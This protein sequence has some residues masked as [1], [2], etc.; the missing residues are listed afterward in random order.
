MGI[1]LSHFRTPEKQPENI[2]IATCIFS[3]AKPS[4]CYEEATMCIVA[5]GTLVRKE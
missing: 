4:V 1:V 2:I 3:V 5:Y